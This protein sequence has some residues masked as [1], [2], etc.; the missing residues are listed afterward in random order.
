[1][2]KII[3][4]HELLQVITRIVH[5]DEVGA[6]KYQEFLEELSG[7]VTIA[8]GGEV[9]TVSYVEDPINDEGTPLGWTVALKNSPWELELEDKTPLHHVFD[10]LNL[11]PE[12]EL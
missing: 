9:G 4:D 12:G 2:A 11:D 6:S 8:L 3:T 1:M 7:A 10:E 5:G